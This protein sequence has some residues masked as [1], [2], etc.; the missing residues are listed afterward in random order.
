M[1]TVDDVLRAANIQPGATICE[2][3]CGDGENYRVVTALA[4]RVE[5]T[6]IDISEAM[7]AHCR[8]THP[9]QRWL[10]A[11]PPYALEDARFDVCL[12]VNVL[13]HLNSRTEVVRMLSEAGRI[14]RKVVLF[15]PLQSDARALA[16]TKSLYWALTDG[17]SRYLRLAEFRALFAEAGLALS[18]ERYSAPLRH[19]YAAHLAAR[20]HGAAT[21]SE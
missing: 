11:S 16:A 20:P 14:A 9:D 19:F 21:G 17:G 7:V 6:G 1:V 12:V 4:G 8:E 5:Y 10:L 18:W 2:I 15:E 3:G 13:H